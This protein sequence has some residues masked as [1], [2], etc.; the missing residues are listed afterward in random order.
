MLRRKPKDKKK[1]PKI[2]GVNTGIT[3]L[4]MAITGHPRIGIL[5]GHYY[6]FVGDSQAG[7]TWVSHT[8]LAEASINPNYDDYRLIY[9]DVEGGALMDMERF[10]GKRLVERME[11]Q[12][13][14]TLEQ[15]YDS[16]DDALERGEK[17]IL[18]QDSNDAL[19]VEA[20]IKKTNTLRKKRKEG[21]QEKESGTYG[22]AKAKLN[23]TRLRS[24]IPKLKKSGS[25]LIIISQ[26]RENLGFGFETKTRAGGKALRF[27]ATIELWLS[28]K[29]KI[30]KT[31]KGKQRGIG[32]LSEIRI[33]K[34]RVQGKDQTCWVPIYYTAGIDDVG[35][36]VQWLVDENH[37]K[38]AKGGISAPEFDFVGSQDN[39]IQLIEE[40]ER[41]RELQKLVRDV[42]REIERQSEVKRK[43]KYK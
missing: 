18:I 34:N 20:D 33:K 15:S 39:L 19:D 12:H 28:I 38:K 43:N 13:S 26:T 6:L 21:T 8:I 23:S 22:T 40:D 36:N 11:V 14:E 5:D 2:K 42:W 27:Y 3:T 17:F 1:N 25:I 29:G 7:K 41:E 35:A 30:K 10:F 32:I 4:N 16:I 9:D 24:F 37:W 31:I